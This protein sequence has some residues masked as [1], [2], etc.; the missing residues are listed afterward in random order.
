M[1]SRKNSLKFNPFPGLRP[2]AEEESDLFFG[3]KKE[4]LEVLGKLVENRFV[5]VIGASGTGKSSLIYCG[6]LPEIRKKA[7][8]EG[9]T[10]R[11]IK[12]RPGNDPFGNL[13]E[14]IAD[15][16][17]GRGLHKT[18]ADDIMVEMHLNADGI[19]GSVTRYLSSEGEKVL[20]VVDQFEELFRYGSAITGGS[21][22]THAAEFVGKLVSAVSDADSRIYTL[23]TMRSDFVGECAHY[24]G[25]TQLINNSNYLVPHMGRANYRDAIEGPVKYA[26]ASID[27]ELVEKILD[28]IG[29]RTDQLPVLQHALMRTWS[30]WEEL[31][32]NDRPV[33]IKDYDA[34]GTMSEAM[35]RHA[36]EAYEELDQQGRELCGKLFR[37][38]TEKG[39][40]N[41]GVRRPASVKSI[42]S[43]TGCTTKELFTVI[44]KFRIPSRSFITPRQEIP[45]TEDSVIDLSHES[46]MRLWDRLRDWVDNESAAVQMYLRLAEASKMYQ[47]GKTGLLRPPDLQLAL[48]WREQQKPTLTWAQR[49]DPAFERAMVY[50]RTSEKAYLDEEESKMRL[51]RR[52]IRRTKI[53][54]GILGV[55]AIISIGFMLFAFV[56]KIAAD[57][58]KILADRN[59]AEAIRQEQL[60][61][62][63]SDS[64][65]Q[66]RVRAD[67]SAGQAIRNAEEAQLQRD[68]ALQEQL[69]AERNA[70]IARL[71]EMIAREQSD[72]ARQARERADTNAARATRERNL[73]RRLRILSIGKSMSVK[74]LQVRGQKD[75]QTLLAYQ[76]YLFNKRN[77]GLPNDADIYAGL[78]DV[79][80]QYG[81]VNYK[82]FR[83]DGIKSIAF[84]PGKREFYT[85]GDDRQI[86]KWSLD[87]NGQTYQVI[88]EGTEIIEVLAISP[89][90]S[91]LAAGSDKASI[92]MIPLRG[93]DLQYT[94]SGH[95]GNIRSLIFSFDGKYL[96]SAA[97]DGKVLKWDL[98]TRTSTDIGSGAGLITAIDISSRGKYLAGLNPEG[99]VILW[100]PELSSDNFR[101]PTMLKD[102]R[103]IRFKPDKNILAIGDVEGN[104]ELWNVDTR[105]KI[106]EVKAHDA[107]VTD[108]KFNPVLGQMATASRDNSLKIYNNTDDL[109]EPPLTFTD[110]DAGFVLVVQ[111]SSDGQLIVSG[112]YQPGQNLVVRPTNA[113]LLAKD[114]CDKLTRNMTPEEWNTYVARDLPPEKTCEQKDLN[115]KINVVK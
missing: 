25:L 100:N 35:S 97:L 39:S 47:Q 28:E 85:S 111:F 60:A 65:T 1:G 81:N 7:T 58:Q 99:N 112:T 79:A 93:N 42:I 77:G 4:S 68:K 5:T 64:A 67:R 32:E 78:Y 66:A 20:L 86:K 69:R 114:M 83:H 88:Y 56:Q 31:D 63:Q 61:L 84:V 53:V 24:Q 74:S 76:A 3:R 70:E 48:N 115:I 37:A 92:R 110:M 12:F 55:A 94:L 16:M 36:N 44:E 23:I 34:V 113:D 82:T 50:L 91:W 105:E 18:A 13:G 59:A 10:W 26:G 30:Y 40:D 107:Q 72:S 54:A 101:L 41:K 15:N 104:V 21:R 14:A 51:Q 8:S 27:N 43:V 71:Q 98:A 80:R 90:A 11:I 38:I 17:R 95:N 87:G 62:I 109:T 2:F 19:K 75:L 73:A 33:G 57:R 106:G 29:D 45:L 9:E 49:Y 52:Q 89:D 6:V 103:A 102:I 46:L 96:Y 22:K 108:I